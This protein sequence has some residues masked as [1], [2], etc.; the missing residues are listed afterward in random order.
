MKTKITAISLSLILSISFIYIAWVYSKNNHRTDQSIIKIGITD[1]Y[2]PFAFLENNQIVGFDVDLVKHIAQKLDK[3]IQ[4][5]EMAFNILI[6]GLQQGKID[7][8]V[9]GL[10]PDSAREKYA[11]FTKTYIDDDTLVIISTPSSEIKTLKDLTGKTVIV[12]EGYTADLFMSKQKGPTLKRL[13][14]IADALMALNAKKGD[15]FVSAL[16]TI[17]PYLKGHGKNKFKINHISDTAETYA[18]LVSKKKPK[19]Y[20]KINTALNELIQKGAIEQLK[21]KWKL[22]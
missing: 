8:I 22:L 10:S 20:K 16:S 4:F 12:N 14:S 5:I 2:P 17:S 19:L 3:K 9:G 1:D 21:K 15:A 13:T 6:S 18:F 7:M 11:L